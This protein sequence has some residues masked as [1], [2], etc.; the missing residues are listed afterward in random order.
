MHNKVKCDDTFG[1]GFHVIG[2]LVELDFHHL[3]CTDRVA[4][5]PSMMILALVPS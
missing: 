4:S 1:I 5:S 3:I 2:F